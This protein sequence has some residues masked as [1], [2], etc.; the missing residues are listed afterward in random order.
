MKTRT[1]LIAVLSLTLVPVALVGACMMLAVG[2][3]IANYRDERNDRARAAQDSRLKRP[4][5]STSGR[6]LF[7]A[8]NDATDDLYVASVD[9]SGLSRLTQLPHGSLFSRPPRVSPDRSR[10][11]IS[12]AGVWI[13]PTD[14]SAGSLRLDRPGGF[15]SQTQPPLFRPQ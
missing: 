15:G 1:I 2:A 6:I 8:Q 4:L 3:G 7:V 10:V 11:A 5:V 13:V 12:S 14:R 9:G